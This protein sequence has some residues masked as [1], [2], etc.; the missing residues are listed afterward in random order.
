[1]LALLQ[2]PT[3]FQT[4]IQ[5]TVQYIMPEVILT[6][7]ACGALILDVMLPRNRKRMVAW[8]SLAGLGFALI[9]LIILYVNKAKSGTSSTAFFDMIVLDNYA[10]VFKLM[11]LIGAALSIL[12]SIRYLEEEG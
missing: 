11:F 12:I 7:F 9:S 5:Q 6:V 8:I 10:V 3:D 4:I 2:T 1:M